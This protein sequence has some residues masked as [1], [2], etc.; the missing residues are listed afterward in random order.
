MYLT[1]DFGENWDND[2]EKLKRD[3]LGGTMRI[4][5]HSSSVDP[6]N[7]SSALSATKRPCEEAVRFFFLRSGLLIIPMSGGA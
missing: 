5:G 6:Y 7:I 1:F 3:K 2:T 4:Y